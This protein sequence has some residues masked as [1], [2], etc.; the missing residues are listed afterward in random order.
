MRAPVAPISR[1]ASGLLPGASALE[2]VPSAAASVP[3]SSASWLRTGAGTRAGDDSAPPRT[4]TSKSTIAASNS[5][6]VDDSNSVAEVSGSAVFQRGGGAAVAGGDLR[7]ASHW[8]S[9]DADIA[10][11][12]IAPVTMDH[13]LSSDGVASYTAAAVTLPAQS[14]DDASNADLCLSPEAG[15][16]IGRGGGNPA[17]S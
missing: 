6:T 12:T 8:T 11:R 5:N 10:V 17:S 9:A 1:A 4:R 14:S 16:Y 2:R 15:E 13:V 7:V 3:A